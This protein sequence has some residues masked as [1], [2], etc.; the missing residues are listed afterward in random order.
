MPLIDWLGLQ[1]LAAGEVTRMYEGE[2]TTPALPPL[3]R[4]K[5]ELLG[6]DPE[7]PLTRPFNL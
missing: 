2:A 5:R 4:Y 6:W 3:V 7:R 1:E